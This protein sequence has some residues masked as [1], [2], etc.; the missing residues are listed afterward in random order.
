[1]DLLKNLCR[2]NKKGCILRITFMT[3]FILTPNILQ[4]SE[5]NR[6]EIKTILFIRSEV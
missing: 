5:F 2:L 3:S 4:Y 6:K 1:M